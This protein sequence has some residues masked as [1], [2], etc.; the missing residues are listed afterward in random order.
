VSV[1]AILSVAVLAAPN[2]LPPERSWS[3]MEAEEAQGHAR[4]D[5]VSG[6]SVALYGILFVAARTPE[7]G[8]NDTS[9][10]SLNC[11]HGGN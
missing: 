11:S 7:I 9:A 3:G 1:R 4:G 8:G 5:R 6:T 2:A 10:L